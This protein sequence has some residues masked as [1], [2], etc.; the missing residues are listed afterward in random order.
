M[1]YG[2]DP[3]LTARVLYAGH[4]IVYTKDVAILHWRDWG[5]SD[6]FRAQ[7]TKQER[8]KALYREKYLRDKLQWCPRWSD[9]WAV[10]VIKRVLA[11]SSRLLGSAKVE[12]WKRDLYNIYLGRYISLFD[13]IRCI[14][15]E[16]H[17]LQH[18]DRETVK[19]HASRLRQGDK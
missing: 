16:F 17:L 14:S 10:G 9:H 7:L 13:P 18:C 3:D 15:K 12:D 4:D 2:I 1:D 19:Y 11:K 6:V 5:E 8:Y